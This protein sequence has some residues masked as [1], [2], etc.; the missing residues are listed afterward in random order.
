MRIFQDLNQS[1]FSYAVLDDEKELK[2]LLIASGDK[3]AVAKW[4]AAQGWKP[5]KDRSGDQYLYG[6]DRFLYYQVEGCRVILCCQA[7]CRSTL[8]GEWIPLD[9]CINLTALQD[10]VQEGDCRVL[11][12]VDRVCY[13]LAKGVYT[14]QH[15]SEQDRARIFAALE[16]ADPQRLL[17]KM[18]MVF[19]RFAEQMIAMARQG[20]FDRMRA[21][22]WGFADY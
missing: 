13:L 4:A 11:C 1:G 5:L 6:M 7:G 9:R 14:E 10:A 15:F 17:E 2:R 19:F 20:E 3:K 21:A 18:R 8:N 22:L 16:Q 12:P